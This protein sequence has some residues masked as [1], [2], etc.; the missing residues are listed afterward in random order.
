MRWDFQASSLFC[1]S[2]QPSPDHQAAASRA[3][4]TAAS[5]SAWP[6]TGKVAITSAVAGLTES[7]VS[8]C[9]ACPG[10]SGQALGYRW[11]NL[12]RPPGQA[13]TDPELNRGDRT[14]ACAAQ[15]RDVGG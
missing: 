8:A 6:W 1:R 10:G 9:V 12:R 15:L 2:F 14:P 13:P 3:R 7:K 4:S 5:I 11:G